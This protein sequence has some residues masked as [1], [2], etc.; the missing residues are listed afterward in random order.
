MKLTYYLEQGILVKFETKEENRDLEIGIVSG[1]SN[2][3]LVR[4]PML[5]QFKYVVDIPHLFD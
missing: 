4:T 3:K 5:I 1:I 2:W